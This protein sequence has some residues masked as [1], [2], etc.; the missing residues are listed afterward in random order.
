MPLTSL[1]KNTIVL[2]ALAQVYCHSLMATD[3]R[4]IPEKVAMTQ[5]GLELRFSN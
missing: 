1:D 3:S 5:K 4:F 2:P